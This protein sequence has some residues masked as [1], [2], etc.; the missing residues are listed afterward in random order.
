VK[1]KAGY[2]DTQ[3]LIFK[4]YAREILLYP[5]IF[6]MQISLNQS[7]S[8]YLF[9]VPFFATFIHSKT[10]LR[11]CSSSLMQSVQSQKFQVFSSVTDATSVQTLKTM[12][13]GVDEICWLVC[14][15]I[16]LERSHS[17]FNDHS[18][19]QLF[20]IYCLLAETD[21]DATDSYLVSDCL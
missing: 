6:K 11:F 5:L 7:F 15:K 3:K 18:V 17:V 1:I 12:E 9:Q 16:Y 10:L 21:S 20:R 14:K 2:S 4:R 8:R 13:E 19:Y